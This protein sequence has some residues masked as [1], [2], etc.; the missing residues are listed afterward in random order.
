MI[1]AH[2]CEYYL[3]QAIDLYTVNQWIMW[4]TNDKDLPG[5]INHEECIY[6]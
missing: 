4:Y 2:I 5:I 1:V 3:L 6:G